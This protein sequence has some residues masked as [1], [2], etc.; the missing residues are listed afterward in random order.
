[1]IRL[2]FN[3]FPFDGKFCILEINVLRAD[4]I[5]V[6]TQLF[7]RNKD[8]VDNVIGSDHPELLVPYGFF[9]S[10]IGVPDV[11]RSLFGSRPH[12]A[13]A[14]PAVFKNGRRLIKLIFSK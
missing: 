11:T 7:F 1:M 2:R 4:A 9:F 12:H 10:L 3:C 5:I 6:V 14:V 8:S 13:V